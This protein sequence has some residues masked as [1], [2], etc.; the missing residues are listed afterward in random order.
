MMTAW[1][2]HLHQFCAVDFDYVEKCS[3][4]IQ[5]SHPYQILMIVGPLRFQ[6]GNPCQRLKFVNV[7][8]VYNRES[9]HL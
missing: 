1:M 4:H 6:C 7:F 9:R 3:T 2:F 8:Q 5:E